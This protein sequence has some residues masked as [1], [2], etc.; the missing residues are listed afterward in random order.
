MCVCAYT[1]MHIHIYAAVQRL[2]VQSCL[3]LCNPMNYSPPGSSVHR[4]SPGKNTEV[5]CHALLQ[6]IFPTQGLN[7]GLPHCRQT[8]YHPT[9][10]RTLFANIQCRLA[11][12]TLISSLR[13]SKNFNST[14]EVERTCSWKSGKLGFIPG[15]PSHS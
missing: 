13:T 5:G 2:V 8:L 1:Y 10:F 15:C 9:T 11:S 12:I 14:N 4:D 7:P 6:G 3:T